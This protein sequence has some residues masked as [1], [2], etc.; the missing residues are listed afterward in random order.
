MET[1]RCSACGETKPTSDF[2]R[3]TRRPDGLQYCCKECKGKIDKKGYQ[4]DKQSY[5]DRTKNNKKRLC[6]EINEIKASKGCLYCE[7]L[8]P[9]CLEFHHLNSATKEATISRLMHTGQ[10]LKALQEVD[11]CDIVCSNCHKK[12]H[13]GRALFPR[14]CYTGSSF[15]GQDAALSRR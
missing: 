3:N 12:L 6:D 10:R 4:K 2:H 15:N 5:I 7:E 11:K 1:K 13:A 9:C 14:Q 8:D